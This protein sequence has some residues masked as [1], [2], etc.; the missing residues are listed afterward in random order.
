MKNYFNEKKSSLKLIESWALAL[1]LVSIGSVTMAATPSYACSQSDVY[2]LL[3]T[4]ECME[5]DLSDVD[6][7]DGNLSSANLSAT[8][9]NGVNLS[10]A[11]LIGTKLGCAYIR[12]TTLPDGWKDIV[13]DY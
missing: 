10:G 6:L 7:S 5:C 3:N 2:Q 9:L 13:A 11:N 8:N 1:V 12:N 4:K